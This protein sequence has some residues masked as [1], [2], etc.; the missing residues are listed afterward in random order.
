MYLFS[1]IKQ[2]SDSEFMRGMKASIPVVL[3][4]IPF[5]LVL[6]TQAVQ[7]GLS[8]LEIPLMTGLNFGGGSEFAAINLWTAAPQ[9]MLIVAVSFLVNSRH[10]LMGAALV[11]YVRH[12]PKKKVLP[13]LF[14]MC[15]ESWALALHDTQRRASLDL[16]LQYYL[17]VSICLYLTWV[18]FT[19][20]GAYF[21]TNVGQL[22][23]FGFDMALTAVFLSLLKGMWQGIRLCYPWAI[24]LV[25]ACLTY[26]FIDG[27]WYV[28]TG[29]VSGLLVAF[30]WGDQT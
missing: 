17:G 27:A 15:D 19:A 10:I 26:Y 2:H 25:I 9:I 21:S 8:P 1:S 28:I 13:A 20:L 6:G 22:E 5:A 14:F 3:A 7:K 11:P 30:M 23:Q 24:S 29:A 18:T 16:S 12:L 4:F